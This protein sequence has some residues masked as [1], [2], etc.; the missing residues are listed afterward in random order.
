M[1]SSLRLSVLIVLAMVTSALSEIDI[2][3]Q[4][5]GIIEQVATLKPQFE[6]VEQGMQAQS[7]AAQQT[8][9]FKV[10]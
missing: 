6:S 9:R 8:S 2:I 1:T 3:T 4:V 7:V 10:R 5:G